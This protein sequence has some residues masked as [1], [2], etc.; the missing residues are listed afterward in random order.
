MAHVSSVVYVVTGSLLL[1][2]RGWPCRCVFGVVW[3]R[4]ILF[5]TCCVG[6]RFWFRLIVQS[7]RVP[8]ILLGK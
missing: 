2:F 8:K 6:V 7:Q 1:A 3:G 4:G 5:A